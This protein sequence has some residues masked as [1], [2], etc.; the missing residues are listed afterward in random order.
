MTDLETLRAC[1]QGIIDEADHQRDEVGEAGAAEAIA[2]ASAARAMLDQIDALPPLTSPD[3]IPP[4]I[5]AGIDRYRAWGLRTGD[6]L[7]RILVGD[8]F[9][10]FLAA[11]PATTEAMPAIVAYIRRELPAVS[12]GSPEAVERWIARVRS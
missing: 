5:R 4:A 9:G 11:D 2:K 12:H 7:Y 8:L 3:R 10:A 6:C 1:A